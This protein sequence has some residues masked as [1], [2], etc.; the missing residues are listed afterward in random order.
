VTACRTPADALA[1]GLADG[2]DDPP[3]SQDK[4]DLVAAILAPYKRTEIVIETRPARG[5]A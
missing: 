4:A 2:K 5:A 1:A 3:L